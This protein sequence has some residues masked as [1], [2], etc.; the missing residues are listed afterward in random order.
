MRV[1]HCKREHYTKYIGRGSELGNPF[2]HLPLSETK[3][4]VHVGSIDEAVACCDQWLRGEPKW[5]HIE[6]ERRRRCP[7][8]LKPI[9]LEVKAEFRIFLYWFKNRKVSRFF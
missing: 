6:P 9:K 4:S 2:T 3:A 8:V 5:A 1:V 7:E